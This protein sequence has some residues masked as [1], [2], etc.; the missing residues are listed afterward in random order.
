ME[1]AELEIR[2]ERSDPFARL[3]AAHETAAV[4]VHAGRATSDP[5]VPRRLVELSG[6]IGGD[7][8]AEP[9]PSWPARSL[10]GALWRLYLLR[11]WMRSDPVTAAREYA[12]GIGF[13][14]PNHAVAGV[15]PPVPDEV[16]RVADEILRGVF[17][18]D[19]A[20]ALER[21]AAFCR[22]VVAGRA[23]ATDGPRA[24]LG[25]LAL[26][27][28]ADDLRACADLCRAGRLD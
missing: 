9:W 23:F 13:T 4:L 7:D 5:D 26:R 1:N 22:V 8:L 17:D 18:G 27:D 24:A 19:V 25:A 28:V 10:P 14:E 2:A 21:A 3:H 20:S 16:A 11:E 15:E 12:W 6:E